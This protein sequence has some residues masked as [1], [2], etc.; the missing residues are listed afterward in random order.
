MKKI[1]SFLVILMALFFVTGTAWSFN[2][3]RHVKIA[4]EGKGDLLIYPF[5]L[6]WPDGW[7]NK[8]TVINTSTTHCVVAKI[9]FRS[10][11]NSDELLDF[12]IYLSPTDVWTG[13]VYHNGTTAAVYSTDGS[14]LVTIDPDVFASASNP[15]DKALYDP[16]C[17]DDSNL[18]GYIE[19]I[20][21]TSFIAASSTVALDT[22][23][24]DVV[25]VSKRYIKKIYDA[26]ATG[27]FTGQLHQDVNGVPT[28][29]DVIGTINA[30]TGYLE[31]GYPMAYLES[32]IQATILKDYNNELKLT[33]ALESKI[34]VGALN[35]IDEI[36][37]ALAKNDLAFQY[38]N[39]ATDISVHF[40]TFPTKLTQY[41]LSGDYKCVCSGGEGAYFDEECEVGY[42]P[43]GY[44]L[45]ERTPGGGTPYS[46]GDCV[47]TTMDNE[48]NYIFVWNFFTDPAFTEGWANYNFTNPVTT[49][50]TKDTSAIKYA[51]APVI[52]TMFHFRN[53][54]FEMEAPAWDW[55]TVLDGDNEDAQIIDYQV[56][57]Q[58]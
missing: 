8:I 5:Y 27:A 40:F 6:A 11:K 49:G 31:F 37:A 28:G 15:M 3:T 57:D 9:V 22:G 17:D 36:E 38:Y 32:E 42:T 20:E 7:E 1:T 21:S 54:A 23:D 33:T 35:T 13:N 53:I 52:G 30:L 46:G 26:L 34:G 43:Y 41:P 18:E 12:L 44:D 25:P 48:M 29:E 39:T 56:T 58:L 10:W 16:Y 50:E 24:S 14:V 45:E 47:S 19:I 51:G 2:E 4:P 55:G